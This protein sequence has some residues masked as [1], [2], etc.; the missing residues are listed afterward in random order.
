MIMVRQQGKLQA[1]EIRIR[2]YK[3]DAENKPVPLTKEEMIQSVMTNGK[4][5]NNYLPAHQALKE[6][7]E[8]GQVEF[9]PGFALQAIGLKWDGKS[10]QKNPQ[11][12]KDEPKYNDQSQ[13]EVWISE[14]AQRHALPKEEGETRTRYVVD[15]GGPQYTASVL[16]YRVRQA[17]EGEFTQA[18]LDTL[19][20][21]HGAKIRTSP[22]AG[23]DVKPNPY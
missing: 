13:I 7:G 4:L 16:S 6:S 15:Q 12:G 9:V 21:D 17:G 19:G 22:N 23:L 5:A 10:M 20:R 18:D 1:D 8:S 14:T 2:N 3:M 11:T